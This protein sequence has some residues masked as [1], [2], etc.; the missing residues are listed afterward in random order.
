MTGK[1]SSFLHD[2][3][4]WGWDTLCQLLHQVW[5]L[6]SLPPSLAWEVLL[7]KSVL[8]AR[9]GDNLTTPFQCDVCHFIDI[10]RREA[11]DGSALDNRLL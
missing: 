2:D 6:D 3:L 9:D 1:L 11:I 4:D 10:M 7:M 5:S 8:M